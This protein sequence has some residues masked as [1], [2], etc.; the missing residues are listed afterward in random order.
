MLDLDSLWLRLLPGG[1]A[2]E[3]EVSGAANAK[4]VAVLLSLWLLIL[5]P[6]TRELFANF[7]TGA[8]G[9]A[10]S[11]NSLKIRWNKGKVMAGQLCGNVA[12]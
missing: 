3:T 9:F 4:P 8:I 1:Y 2:R 7:I 5:S 10:P 11:G 6:R 12:T